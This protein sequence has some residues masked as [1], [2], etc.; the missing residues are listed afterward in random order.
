M[1]YVIDAY[2]EQG[3]PSLT[4]IDS[5]TGEKRL[6]WQG[7]KASGQNAWL[8]LFKR[9]MLLSCADKLG[10]MERAKSPEFGTECNECVECVEH[11][12]W[13]RE[14][15]PARFVNENGEEVIPFSLGSYAKSHFN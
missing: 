12:Q 2:L 3:N 9:L 7:D 6:H 10:L 11:E 14:Y 15:S 13:L 4:L 1:A 8:T 5:E